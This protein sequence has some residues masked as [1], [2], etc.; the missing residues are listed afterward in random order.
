MARL[1]GAGFGV[2]RV[3]PHDGLR[4]KRA[5]FLAPAGCGGRRFEIARAWPKRSVVT[6]D[7]ENRVLRVHL[8]GYTAPR[9]YL[10]PRHSSS[11]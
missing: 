10:G 1:A 8:I 5:A 4:G 2:I 6:G 7:A 9:G 3:V 11:Y